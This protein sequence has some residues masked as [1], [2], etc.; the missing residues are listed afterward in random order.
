MQHT[1]TH[2][3][4]TS[5]HTHAT[6]PNTNMQ[7]IQKH[8]C[9]TFKPTQTNLHSNEY[10]NARTYSRTHALST[11]AYERT[12]AYHTHARNSIDT[13][14]IVN[15]KIMLVHYSSTTAD[16]ILGGAESLPV[17]IVLKRADLGNHLLNRI[18]LPV[19]ILLGRVQCTC[20]GVLT[21]GS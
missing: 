9:N 4:N 17:T 18:R 11:G 13:V 7:H 6:H 3:C 10:A 12:S 2:T 16:N 21:V 5:K 20:E 8:T 1:Q 19:V 15:N 14:D